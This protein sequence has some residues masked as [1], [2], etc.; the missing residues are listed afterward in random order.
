M[1]NWEITTNNNEESRATEYE[2]SGNDFIV[3]SNILIYNAILLYKKK[4]SKTNKKVP[5]TF[6]KFYFYEIG[7]YE[8]LFDEKLRLFFAKL[9]SKETQVAVL[10]KTFA[11][12]Y[13]YFVV[14][15][16]VANFAPYVQTTNTTI[17]RGL[18]VPNNLDVYIKNSIDSLEKAIEHYNNS[19]ELKSLNYIFKDYLYN[20]YKADIPLDLLEQQENNTATDKPGQETNAAAQ[21]SGNSVKA[22]VAENANKSALLTGRVLEIP[23]QKG[24]VV[25]VLF[26]ELPLPS[27]Y[28]VLEEKSRINP[29]R[30]IRRFLSASEEIIFINDKMIN[31]IKYSL[32]FVNKRKVMAHDLEKAS[33]FD[34]KF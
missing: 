33:R 30:K 23:K 6:I 17:P 24:K 27:A 34:F 9:N 18:L 2:L 1:D 15:E 26:P 4:I 3:L 5:A 31:Q 14:K 20:T 25:S 22:K 19:D 12:S 13:P 21:T 32:D 8:H 11:N 10:I 16:G 29:L 28:P 7:G